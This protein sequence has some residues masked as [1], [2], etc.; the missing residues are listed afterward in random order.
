MRLSQ[1]TDISV[2]LC[3]TRRRLTYAWK[4][5]MNDRHSALASGM[6]LTLVV[7]IISSS[8]CSESQGEIGF[9]MTLPK[10]LVKDTAWFEIGAFR[11]ATCSALLPMLAGG[12]PEG[13]AAVERAGTYWL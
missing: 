3:F 4:P 1:T 11:N 7:G 5:F 12:V 10:N 2:K 6:M 8:G 13:A 9:D